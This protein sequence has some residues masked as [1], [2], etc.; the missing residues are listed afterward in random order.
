MAFAQLG[1]KQLTGLSSVKGLADVSG[2]IPTGS[3]SVLLQAES[4]SIRWRDDGTDPTSS[5]GMVLAAGDSLLYDFPLT[6]IKFIESTPSAK[7]NI[8]FWGAN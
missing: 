3:H 4:Q 5:T 1:Y 8:T 6:R 2:G 7:L